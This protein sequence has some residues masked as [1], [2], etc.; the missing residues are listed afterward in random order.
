MSASDAILKRKPPPAIPIIV[1]TGFLGAGKTTLLNAWVK[2]PAFADAAVV[3]NEFGTIGLDH[4]LVEK[5]EGTI[6]TLSSGCLCCTI[7]GDMIETLKDLVRRRDNGRIPP[8]ARLVIE[9]TGL[10]DP[11]PI[12]NTIMFHPYLPLRYRI[13]SV[14]TAVD[15]IHGAAT[16]AAHEEAL[17]QVAVADTLILTKTDLLLSG[18]DAATAL[19]LLR[20]LNPGA[21]ILDAAKGEAEAETILGEGLFAL[22]QRS[23]LVRAW[24]N[25][26]R[27]EA[28]P[29]AHDAGSHHHGH[30][31]DHAH[32]ALDVNRHDARIKAT[33]LTHEA[34]LDPATFG[35]FVDLLRANY[36]GQLLRV[37]GIVAL[38]TDP[39]HPLVIH[40]VQHTFHPAH[41]L[42]AWPDS[43]HRSRL[44]FIARDLQPGV[45]EALWQGF[46]GPPSIDRPDGAALA[47]ASTPAQTGGLF[48]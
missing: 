11:A 22:D 36:G 18:D 15:A 4:L 23:D 33:C 21:R 39:D 48:G 3:I 2:T 29:S 24:L 20:E 12:L 30:G 40:G 7:R 17:K 44:V 6:L 43:D 42:D 38:A 27:Y 46:F 8:F 26:A 31:H 5:A 47:A 25:P 34:P 45:I 35:M 1:L 9:T 41:K 10:A 14:V 32:H 13:D 16:V 37:K 28:D 19:T